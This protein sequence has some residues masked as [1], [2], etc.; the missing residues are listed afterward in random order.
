VTVLRQIL[1]IALGLGLA[2]A[3]V[4][5]GV[6]QLN[7]YS[8]QGNKSAQAKVEEAPL[9]LRQVAVPG[10][11]VREGFGHSVSFTGRYEPDLQ[12]LVPLADT[13]GTF[14]VLSGLRQADG[15]IVPVVRGLVSSPATPPPPPS[16]TVTEV[17]VLLPSEENAP[18]RATPS[19]QLDAVRLPLLAQRWPGQ[20]VGGYVTLSASEAQAQGIQPAPLDLPEAKGRLRNAAYAFQWWLF[21]AFTVALS[22]RIAR[23]I[24]LQDDLDAVEI[25]AA[26]DSNAT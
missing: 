25:T 22:I 6:W 12:L 2:T 18:D 13:P 14:R 11:A 10:A 20:L 9:D 7:V 24:R 1:V 8:S 3:M 19:D 17:G 16:S 15:S 26:V 4:V 21:A 23:D 5:L